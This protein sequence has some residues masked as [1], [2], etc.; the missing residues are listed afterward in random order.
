M[1][2]DEVRLDVTSW[3][4]WPVYGDGQGIAV[5][6]AGEIYVS[7]SSFIVLY[8]L[9][10]EPSIYAGTTR[11]LRFTEGDRLDK[12]AFGTLGG[13]RFIEDLLYF[14][15]RRFCII[16]Y[17]ENDMVV[18]YAGTG[19]EGRKDGPRL[20]ATF[21]YPTDIIHYRGKI[22]VSDYD[23][24]YIRVI[25]E[26][27]MVSSISADGSPFAFCSIGQDEALFVS[28]HMHNYIREVDLE[29]K[30]TRIVAGTGREGKANGAIETS[31]FHRPRG[32]VS[33]GD[34]NILFVADCHNHC[35]RQITAEPMDLP[36]ES[37]A[38]V[39]LE[40]YSHYRTTPKVTP[41]PNSM[42]WKYIYDFAGA[43]GPHQMPMRLPF[44]MTITRDGEL[45]WT[46]EATPQLLSIK[47]FTDPFASKPTLTRMTTKHFVPFDILLER[48][49]N[50]QQN[51]IQIGRSTVLTH[52]ASRRSL[53]IQP[54]L[55]SHSLPG[56][57][58]QDKKSVE[59][60]DLPFETVELFFKLLYG[61]IEP[62]AT[63]KP[64]EKSLACLQLL[65]L[66]RSLGLDDRDPLY[67]V[68]FA[69]FLMSLDALDLPSL[70]NVAISIVMHDSSSHELLYVTDAVKKGQY[71]IAKW[72]G[73]RGTTPLSKPFDTL[74]TFS[75]AHQLESQFI[76][77]TSGL[78]DA[79]SYPKAEEIVSSLG[80]QVLRHDFFNQV[81]QKYIFPFSQMQSS[82]EEMAT[83]LAFK[84]TLSPTMDPSKTIVIGIAGHSKEVEVH[85]W[86]VWSRW[87]YLKR[88]LG[89]GG[90]ES[91][92]RR[93]ELPSYFPASLLL[94]LLQFI[95]TGGTTLTHPLSDT[96]CLFVM[97]YGAEFDLYEPNEFHGLYRFESDSKELNKTDTATRGTT[98]T[99]P[100]AKP[101]FITLVAHSR[102]RLLRSLT[103][104]NCL[105]SLEYRLFCGSKRQSEIAMNFV[106]SEWENIKQL[107][108][109]LY[110]SLIAS[111]SQETLNL[112]SNSTD[113]SF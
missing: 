57:T 47:N 52:A 9:K 17:I 105:P 91:V 103:L 99:A 34:N 27:G 45:L 10:R 62:L 54:E 24:K 20:Q 111:L 19:E 101:G 89:A 69:E 66:L 11:R 100:V 95:Y 26:Q 30:V 113:I 12:A 76:E 8:D 56:F 112:I 61:T 43:H 84:D 80:L 28:C 63:L 68:I 70:F 74:T 65:R 37:T 1:A 85:D 7:V 97:T 18:K 33:A 79:E 40:S 39:E 42:G 67:A 82:L 92:S 73:K 81:S 49:N 25:D 22:L 48:D 50:G 29:R 5:G 77:A 83:H 38:P 2:A 72:P 14:V 55:V 109:E 4:P 96:D 93:L 58:E 35:I 51:G 13:L 64:Q 90:A 86:V 107:P 44:F 23:N 41:T 60:S 15:D 59:K 3:K 16:G 32:M 36:T 94:P 106:R 46:Q 31:T 71:N 75:F 87:E 104:E 53:E 6:S 88:A 110:H 102:A 78:S 21:S 108:L 98:T